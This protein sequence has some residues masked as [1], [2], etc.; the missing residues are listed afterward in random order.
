MKYFNGKSGVYFDTQKEFNDLILIEEV[1]P[2]SLINKKTFKITKIKR[3]NI[4]TENYN[5]KK[6]A[7]TVSKHLVYIGEL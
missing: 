4:Q 1:E 3:Y 7:L 5:Y 6:T 2:Y